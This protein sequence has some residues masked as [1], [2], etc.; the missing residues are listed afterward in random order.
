MPHATFEQRAGVG[1]A[2]VDDIPNP[3]RFGAVILVGVHQ[4]VDVGGVFEH[5]RMVP[6]AIE[7]PLTICLAHQPVRNGVNRR[8]E[9][10]SGDGLG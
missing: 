5:A 7:A 10:E 2:G 4:V 1:H 6:D 8:S 3:T 9:G